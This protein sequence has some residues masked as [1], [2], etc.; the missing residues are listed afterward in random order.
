MENNEPK[1][2]LI[3][4]GSPHKEK[5]TTMMIT[6]AFT[7]GILSAGG[8]EAET[9]HVSNLKVKPCTGCLSCWGR[10]EGECVI[11]T[12]DMPA[13]KRKLIEADVVIGSFPLYYF[14]VP[15]ILKVVMDRL[16]SMVKAYHGQLTPKDDSPAHEFRYPKLGKKY[17]LI[18]GCAYTETDVVYVPVRKQVD[19]IL[20]KNN[21]TA[22]FCPQFKTMA[23]NG[24]ARKERILAKFVKAG[25]EFAKN[26]C[27]SQKTVETVTKPPF[28]SEVYKT[29]LNSVWAGEKLKGGLV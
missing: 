8:Y 28:S 6:D 7:R 1:K 21:Y 24:G 19:L 23:D 29:I 13:L 10:T 25:E 5:S 11:K 22:L 27:L 3:I 20:G 14:G 26:G 2:I 12:D 16:L 4:N 9:V 17:V 15:G 18:S